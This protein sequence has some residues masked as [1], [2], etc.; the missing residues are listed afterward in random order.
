MQSFRTQQYL[1]DFSFTDCGWHMYGVAL[2]K[3]FIC[4][5]LVQYL[6]HIT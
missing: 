5:C 2:I 4:R 6:Y 3:T 1:F